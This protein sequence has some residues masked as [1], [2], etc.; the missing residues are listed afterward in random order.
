MI[1]LILIVFLVLF[2]FV[3]LGGGRP[4]TG[5]PSS[6]KHDSHGDAGPVR[7]ENQKDGIVVHV[8]M[9]QAV[10][11]WSSLSG[12]EKER[13]HREG[14]KRREEMRRKERDLE[15]S[16]V[17]MSIQGVIVGLM[18]VMN[19]PYP[20]TVE[21]RME[22]ILN[23]HHDFLASDPSL[24][25]EGITYARKMLFSGRSYDE[26]RRAKSL[27]SS[28]LSDPSG[29][30]FEAFKLEA[31]RDFFSNYRPK[32]ESAISDLVRKSAIVKRR[33]YLVEKIGELLA[34]VDENRIE[35]CREELEEY[36]QLN[37]DELQKLDISKNS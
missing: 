13:R 4:E 27:L 36:R 17:G 16:R 7:I 32:W 37:L 34:F 2:L 31:L 20:F 33:R 15:V 28:Y 5:S 3:Y 14:L 24:V 9:A 23:A 35:G 22:S 25:P 8:D 12:E 18:D 26:V 29:F 19:D 10:K 1:W 21:K 11:E 30:D 6:R